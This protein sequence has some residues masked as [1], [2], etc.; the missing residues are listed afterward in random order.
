MVLWD[1]WWPS[2]CDVNW[3][4]KN[5]ADHTTKFGKAMSCR[6]S[7]SRGFAYRRLPLSSQLHDKTPQ[8]YFSAKNFGEVG[9]EGVLEVTEASW[10]SENFLNSHI[11]R[12]DSGPK[13]L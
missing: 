8:G 13:I 11:V 12:L 2:E 1:V 6:A 5:P 3:A 4:K 9:G 7:S 10:Y